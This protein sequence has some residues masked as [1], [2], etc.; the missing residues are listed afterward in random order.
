M[1]SSSIASFITS[2]EQ[3]KEQTNVLMVSPLN[4][5]QISLTDPSLRTLRSTCELSVPIQGG[6]CTEN[7]Y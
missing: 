5:L 6:S 2:I 3:Q 7:Q 4:L 1:S